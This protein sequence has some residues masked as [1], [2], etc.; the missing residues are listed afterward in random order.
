MRRFEKDIESLKNLD[1]L[2]VIS[3]TEFEHGTIRLE[4]SIRIDLP[5][6]SAEY[7][8]FSRSNWVLIISC[9]YPRGTIDV[10][11]AIDN[12]I[13]MTFP[14]QLDNSSISEK[15]NCRSGKVC[16][17]D[18][19]EKAKN[20]TDLLSLNFNGLVLQKQVTRLRNYLEYAFQGKLQNPGE[21][22][23]FPSIPGPLT[24]D[25]HLSFQES[26]ESFLKWNNVLQDFGYFSY[27][28]QRFRSKREFIFPSKFFDTFGV[29]VMSFSWSSEIQYQDYR[30]QNGI[31]VKFDYHP[32]RREWAFPKTYDD[33]IN[34]YPDIRDKLQKSLDQA[35]SRKGGL[36]KNGFTVVL[37]GFPVPYKYREANA[38]ITW[39]AFRINLK[40]IKKSPGSKKKIQFSQYLRAVFS[41]IPKQNISWMRTQNWSKG[42]LLQRGKSSSLENLSAVIVGGGALG[43]I[44]TENLIRLGMDKIQIHDGDEIEAGNLCRYS[45][46]LQDVGVQ[47][48]EYLKKKL[49][50]V[51]PGVAVTSCK[52]VFPRDYFDNSWESYDMLIDI[53]GDDSALSAFEN[54]NSKKEKIW[55]TVFLGMNAKRLYFFSS[56]S[57]KFLAKRFRDEYSKWAQVEYNE[58]KLNRSD[59]RPEG[60]GCWDPL[61]PARLDDIVSF[62]SAIIT[63]IE[64]ATKLA[65]GEFHFCVY[66]KVINKDMDYFGI[67]KVS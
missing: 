52:H 7:T 16:L 51:R 4:L 11:P 2:K 19:F 20:R 55:I 10:Y 57:S 58:Q 13:D 22:F 15:F 29:E 14:H 65:S 63:N 37:L 32:F 27:F 28:E 60:T 53:S 21:Y 25:L 31:W 24:K 3:A 42:N 5:D 67:R 36:P 34:I 18:Y 48:S 12:G 59:F 39:L 50:L 23:E 9:D 1:W 6:L 26:P 35:A 45:A 47:K 56:K 49:E 30:E 38:E 66:E 54:Y 46:S 62:T 64:R 43:S 40:E 44:V 61:F 17:A 41:S 33:L 8:K